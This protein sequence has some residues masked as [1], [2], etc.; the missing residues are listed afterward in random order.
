MN[1]CLVLHVKRGYEDREQSIRDQFDAL[2]LPFE[3]VLDYD[4]DDVNDEV[5]A[6]YGY[7]GTLAPNVISC[8]L[9]HIRAW[10]LIAASRA[11]GAF[12]FEDDVLIDVARFKEITAAALREFTSAGHET[13]YISL[14]D[15]CALYVPWTVKK[16][17]VLLYPAACVRAADSYWINHQTACF[18]IAWV[19]EH[20]FSLPADHLLDQICAGAGIPIFWLAPTVASQGSHTGRFASTIQQADRGGIREMIT[21]KIK[22]LRRKYLYPLL[23]K[24]LRKTG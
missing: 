11:D 9:K 10:E 24:D 7:H 5:L 3:W 2:D 22:V 23:G 17:G 8:S 1:T 19:R 20:G 16:K 12:V 6:R 18:L 14:G 15:G 13:G 21:W 4:R